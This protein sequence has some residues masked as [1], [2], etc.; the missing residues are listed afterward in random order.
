MNYSVNEVIIILLI[1]N[2]IIVIFYD[3]LVALSALD[4]DNAFE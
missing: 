3:Y 1:P 2:N 4:F